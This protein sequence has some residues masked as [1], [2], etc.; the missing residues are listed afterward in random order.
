MNKI[1]LSGNLTR[2]PELKV[3]DKA[4]VVKF[5]IAVKRFAK[6]EVDFFNVVAFGKTA[7]FCNQ[8][9]DKGR[10]AIIEGRLQASNYTDKDGN[11]RTSYDVIVESIEFGDSKRKDNSDSDAENYDSGEQDKNDIDVPF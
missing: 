1:F 7:E 10:R 9:F 8:Y 2:A 3:Y 5:G 4:T 6:D 11:K